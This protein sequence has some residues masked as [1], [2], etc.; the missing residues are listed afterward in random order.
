LLECFLV[1]ERR[2]AQPMVDLGFFRLPTYVGA[3]IAGLA[4]AVSFLTM[5]TYLPLYFQNVMGKTA[6]DSG[7]M[8]LP[9]ALPLFV[10]P[11]LVTRYA[12]HHFSGRTFLAVGLGLVAIGLILTSFE[13]AGF[14]YGVI[15]ASMLIASFGAGI[16]NAEVTKV[17]MTVIPADRA[18][19]ASGVAS[20]V[21]ISGIVVGFAALGAIMY[22]RIKDGVTSGFAGMSSMIQ[23][24]AMHDLASG[25]VTKNAT[26]I[27]GYPLALLERHIFVAG[28]QAA[29]V[30]AAL[31]AMVAALLAWCLISP[32]ETSGY[33]GDVPGAEALGIPME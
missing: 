30:A 15:L 16:L 21:R 31:I 26:L 14:H 28:Y 19:M 32:T 5:L 10:V 12:Q 3:N 13:I 4:Y 29:I 9:I 11:R 25:A 2:Q 24:T 33:R 22:A 6:M 17:G 1:V 20:T 23:S 18:G 7:F 27:D 8:M